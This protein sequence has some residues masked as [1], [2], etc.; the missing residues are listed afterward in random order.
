MWQMVLSGQDSL[1]A[2]GGGG[3]GY[4]DGQ[5]RLL[6]PWDFNSRKGLSEDMERLTLSKG[7]FTN[8]P[9]TWEHHCPR[10]C[11]EEQ[12]EGRGQSLYGGFCGKGRGGQLRVG[13]WNN[14]SGL[15]V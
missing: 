15:A 4:E 13:F 12:G 9:D 6:Y 1:E 7:E 11:G 8:F 14:S 5:V 3:G 10:G 2:R